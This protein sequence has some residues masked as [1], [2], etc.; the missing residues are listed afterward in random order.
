MHVIS[1]LLTLVYLPLQRVVL[2]EDVYWVYEY[3]ACFISSATLVKN[4]WLR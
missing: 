2:G 1:R 3:I 4:I